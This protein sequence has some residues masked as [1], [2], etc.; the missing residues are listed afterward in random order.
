VAPGGGTQDADRLRDEARLAADLGFEA[1]FVEAVPFFGVAGIEYR[2]QAKF[3]PRK[4][5][6]AL[7]RM[8]DGGGSYV[9]EHTESEE[10]KEGPRSVR[11]NGHTISCGDIVIATHTPLMGKTNMASALALQTKL[12]LYTSYA[13]GGRLPSGL[14]PEAC[15]WDT[16]DP[17]HYLRVDR[18]R[19][20][21]FAVYGGRD[22]KTG[23]SD[24]TGDCF[25]ALERDALA[26]L[27]QLTITHRWSGQV[28]ETNDGLPFIG[29]TSAH[30][31]AAT[32]YAGNGMTFGT[33]AGMMAHDAVVGRK[34]PWRDLFD[35]SRTKVLGATWDYIKE[36]IDYPYYLIRDR[37]AGPEGRTLRAVRRGE[38]KILEID[39]QRVAA[40][41]S[42]QGRVTTLSPVCTHL[43]CEVRWNDA[44]HT[45]DCPCHGSRFTPA[46]AVL[47]GPAE[48]PLEKIDT[49]GSK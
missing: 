40:Y 31:F 48:T 36:N 1:T 22:H 19:G 34:N 33:L 44:E 20:F 25:A 15:F 41:R 37:F 10:A 42:E 5:L 18:H 8:V 26:V 28:V 12:Y 3:H 2:G 4:Y 17:Y 35:P 46:G 11:A 14:I 30:Q 39:G 7:A 9:F 32:G 29:E 16:A 13:I 47:S 43:G 6:A 24:A 49:P 23:Q 27:P 38:G 45:W 21:D